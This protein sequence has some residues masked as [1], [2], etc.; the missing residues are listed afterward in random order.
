MGRLMIFAAIWAVP[1][2]ALAGGTPTQFNLDCSGNV[3]IDDIFGTK[4]ETYHSIYRL[5]LDRGLWCDGDCK[6]THSFASVQPTQIELEHTE[7][8]T[9]LSFDRI[10]RETGEHSILMAHNDVLDRRSVRT[11]KWSG[12]CKRLDFT[13]FPSFET[14]F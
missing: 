6:A 11:M 7:T 4:S 3:V 12:E 10:N 14:K 1:I 8:D 9:D 13:G 5:D 2:S